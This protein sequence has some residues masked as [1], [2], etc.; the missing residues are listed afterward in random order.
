MS[1]D[2]AREKAYADVKM[3]IAND[4]ELKE[5][6]PEAFLLTKNEASTL[7]HVVIFFFTFWWTLGLGNLVYYFAK[8]KKKKILK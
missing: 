5:E 3:Y 2:E 4:W 7:G 8:K 6:T 1:K